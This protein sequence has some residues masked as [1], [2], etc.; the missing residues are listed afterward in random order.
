MNKLS[1]VRGAEAEATAVAVAVPT[2]L[3][4]ASFIYFPAVQWPE[5]RMGKSRRTAS[6]ER[7][8]ADN[9]FL[10]FAWRPHTG[11]MRN[12]WYLKF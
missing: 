8:T 10:P 3:L 6:G 5:T 11:R 4:I 1:W 7:A 12:E 2:F 9:Y